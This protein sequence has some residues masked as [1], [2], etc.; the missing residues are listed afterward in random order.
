MDKNLLTEVVR[1]IILSEWPGGALG[2]DEVFVIDS[3]IMWLLLDTIEERF[4]VKIEIEQFDF[5]ESVTIASLAETFIRYE[6]R[7]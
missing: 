3:Y 2:D 6:R 1:D 7:T 4:S 5:D